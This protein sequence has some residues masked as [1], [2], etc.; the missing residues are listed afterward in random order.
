M[1][2]DTNCVFCKIIAGDAPARIV[3]SWSDA[4][5]FVP[6]VPVTPGHVLVVPREHVADALARPFVTAL[7][8]SLATQYAVARGMTSVNLLTSA[9][10]AATQSVFHLHVHVVPRSADDGLMLPW[11]TAY[12]ENPAA[13]HRCRQMIE[14]ERRL[15]DSSRSSGS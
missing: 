15:A 3:E 9:G 10:V 7:T 14:L 12:G 6:L 13:P 5:A 1:P 4:I 11:G 8:F 2:P